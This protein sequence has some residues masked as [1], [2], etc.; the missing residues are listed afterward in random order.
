MRYVAAYLL[1]AQSGAAPSKNAIYKILEAVGT[2]IDTDKLDKVFSEL[3]GKSVVD[4][5]ADGMSCLAS[6][7]SGRA[8]W[9]FDSILT[10]LNKVIIDTSVP[11]FLRTNRQEI[12]KLRFEAIKNLAKTNLASVM[13]KRVEKLS[14]VDEFSDGSI[15]IV[16]AVHSVPEDKQN[17]CFDL[18]SEFFKNGLTLIYPNCDLYQDD[19]YSDGPKQNDWVVEQ[20]LDICGYG[21]FLEATTDE[22]I[23]KFLWSLDAIKAGILPKGL[24][25]ENRLQQSKR[26]TPP[27]DTSDDYSNSAFNFSNPY[28]YIPQGSSEIVYDSCGE[29]I[30]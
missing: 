28:A 26:T 1:A 12:Y 14:F 5:V 16:S 10:Q 25:A 8:P 7:P 18:I 4:V 9:D 27:T 19:D 15:W 17:E 30:C 2:E 24:D 3:D 11:D 20:F 13:K 6:V 29:E 22:D 21:N 23:H